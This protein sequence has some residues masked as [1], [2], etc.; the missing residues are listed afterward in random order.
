MLF[1]WVWIMSTKKAGMVSRGVIGVDV[2]CYH[3]FILKKEEALN[4]H[5]MPDSYKQGLCGSMI[6]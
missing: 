4:Y 5:Y 6:L 2:L 1:I 3:V